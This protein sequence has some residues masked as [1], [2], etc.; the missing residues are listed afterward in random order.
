MVSL[1]DQP[2]PQGTTRAAGLHPASES[3]SLADCSIL[4]DQWSDRRIPGPVFC[5]TDLSNP[6]I[7]AS[8]PFFSQSAQRWLLRPLPGDV[9]RP[10]TVFWNRLSEDALMLPPPSSGSCM[11]ALG[12][13]FE[14]CIR[15]WTGL[16]TPS[17]QQGTEQPAL[18]APTILKAS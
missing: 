5:T 10:V 4:S 2:K 6:E 8:T 3:S 11:Q 9:G 14:V 7:S 15:I 18:Y 1:Q 16:K 12:V 13:H 17:L